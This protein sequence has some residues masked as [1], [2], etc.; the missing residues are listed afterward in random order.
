[1]GYE[2]F[3]ALCDARHVTP[4]EVSKQTG[5]TTATLSSWKMGRYNPK[6][7]KLKLLADYFDVPVEYLMTGEMPH[8]YSTEEA[9]DYADFLLHNPDYKILFDA[10]RNVKREDLELVA[11]LVRRFSGKET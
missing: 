6:P 11:E 7:D 4:Y 9:R 3:Q 1:M 8:Y 2:H 5:V 10:S